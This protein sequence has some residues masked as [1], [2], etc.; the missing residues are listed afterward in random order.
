MNFGAGVRKVKRIH[1]GIR[2]TSPDFTATAFKISLI[3]RFPFFGG[4]KSSTLLTLG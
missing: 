4:C 3:P 2:S 1:E